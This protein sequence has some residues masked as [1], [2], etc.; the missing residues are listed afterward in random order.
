MLKNKD[1]RFGVFVF[2]FTLIGLILYAEYSKPSE[3]RL[4]E[5]NKIESKDLAIKP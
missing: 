5:I 2:L 3:E 4:S 1:I